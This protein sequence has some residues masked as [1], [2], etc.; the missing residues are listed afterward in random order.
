M[1]LGYSTIVAPLGSAVGEF[2]TAWWTNGLETLC[3]DEGQRIAEITER[4]V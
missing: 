4:A 3:I 1:A 2:G